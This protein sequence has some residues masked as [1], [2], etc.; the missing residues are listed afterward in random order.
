MPSHSFESIR[1]D[2]E[3]IPDYVEPPHVDTDNDFDNEL[4]DPESDDDGEDSSEFGDNGFVDS[5]SDSEEEESDGQFRPQGSDL[6]SSPVTDEAGGWHE[7]NEHA[8]GQKAS[9]P[10]PKNA[11][12]QQA[13]ALVESAIAIRDLLEAPPPPPTDVVRPARATK[14]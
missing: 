12:R 5:T 2:D 3:S 11:R 14:R 1:V 9:Q 13:Q 7:L 10:K 4:I 8:S 6:V